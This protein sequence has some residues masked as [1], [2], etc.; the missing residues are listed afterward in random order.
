MAQHF[1]VQHKEA[2]ETYKNIQFFTSHNIHFALPQALTN[3]TLYFTCIFYLQF[4]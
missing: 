4:S 1:L 2:N 3:K